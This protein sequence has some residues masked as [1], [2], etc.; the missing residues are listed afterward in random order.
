MLTWVIS[1]VALAGTILNAEKIRTGFW[2]WLGSNMFWTVYDFSI[3]AYAQGAL[4]AVY[5][6][7]AVRGLIVWKQK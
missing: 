3:G 1:A 7:L 5:T 6:L 2:L 4:F